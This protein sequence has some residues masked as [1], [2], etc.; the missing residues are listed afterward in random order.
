MTLTFH[1]L[2]VFVAGALVAAVCGCGAAPEEPAEPRPEPV[3]ET[4]DVDEPSFR[5]WSFGVL[6]EATREVSLPYLIGAGGARLEEPCY[7]RARGLN[8][9]VT[10]RAEVRAK[11]DQ[12]AA[13]VEQA[14]LEWAAEVLMPDG[15]GT[16]GW[17]AS[18]ERPSIVHAP[19]EKVRLAGDQQCVSEKGSLPEGSKTVT[20]LFGAKRI[21]LKSP[22][23]LG[24][25]LL[26][27]ARKTA[28]KAKVWLKPLRA[29]RR[30]VDE[31][32][33]PVSGPDGEKL[34]VSPDGR[35][36]PSEQIPRGAK[37]RIY[38]LE[39]NSYQ[40]LWFA[41]GDLPEETWV[42]E[43]SSEKCKVNLV[44]DDATPR[45]TDCGEP[46]GVGFGVGLLGDGKMEVRVAA[47]G[48]T[49]R[50]EAKFDDVVMIPVGGR[51]VV[52]IKI[53]KI[54]EGVDLMVNSLVLDPD[55]AEDEPPDSFPKKKWPP[56]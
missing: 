48:Y 35:L 12:H 2:R 54:L 17:S 47:D 4:P 8:P 49:A 56:K 44:Y 3:T 55:S 25:Q 10:Q 46:A 20:T 40:P 53:R 16:A 37:R 13:G 6:D 23:P 39:L 33:D 7:Q 27:R 50:S 31:D 41:Y 45:P 22:Q 1:V 34:F 42:S 21:V 24:K 18:Y 43:F 9:W 51:V 15:E 38:E 30:A 52:W 5:V 29:Y 28:K 36:V 14:I 32:G 19:N 11:L 26:K